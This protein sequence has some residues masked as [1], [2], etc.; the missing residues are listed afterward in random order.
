MTFTYQPRSTPPPGRFLIP[1]SAKDQVKSRGIVQLEGLG[2]LKQIQWPYVVHVEI[3]VE[4][5]TKA[6]TD[7]HKDSGISN[8]T[9][10]VAHNKLC[11]IY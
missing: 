7:E 3:L 10:T 8:R 1:I 11:N 9:V 5:H 2:K 4:M 6:Y